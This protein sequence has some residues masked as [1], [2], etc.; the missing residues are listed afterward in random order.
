MTFSVVKNFSRDVLKI[1]RELRKK[2]MNILLWI[3]LFALL[4]GIMMNYREFFNTCC[5]G[6]EG[7]NCDKEGM[8]TGHWGWPGKKP[9]AQQWYSQKPSN[10][11]KCNKCGNGD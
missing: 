1:Y 7:M 6:K 10:C 8:G 3:F 9:P 11:K 4:S 5:T 2:K